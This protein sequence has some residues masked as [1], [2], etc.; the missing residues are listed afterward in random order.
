MELFF[1]LFVV[2]LWIYLTWPEKKAPPKDP[3]EEL[4][5]AIGNA[6]KSINFSGSG[7]GG[8]GGGGGGKKK[9]SSPVGLVLTV[10]LVV[11]LVSYISGLDRMMQ[12]LYL[13]RD[14]P[15]GAEFTESNRA[16]APTIT[17]PLSQIPSSPLEQWVVI[18]EMAILRLG[19]GESYGI[20]TQLPFGTIVAVE[21]EQAMGSAMGALWP[22]SAW[23]QV[24]LPNGQRGFVRHHE[25]QKILI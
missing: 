20:L 7:G 12:R 13:N 19:P 21:A 4:G 14:Q 17:P 8:G 5:K 6:V 22:E 9:E 24:Q 10:A 3:W 2:G 23:R 15:R 1:I 11:A 18:T 25:V 16:A